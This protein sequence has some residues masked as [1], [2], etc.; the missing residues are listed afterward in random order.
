MESV[1]IPE[2]LEEERRRSFELSKKTNGEKLK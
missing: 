1:V 2:R